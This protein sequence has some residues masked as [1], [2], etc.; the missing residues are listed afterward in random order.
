MLIMCRGNVRMIWVDAAAQHNAHVV[1]VFLSLRA[2][3]PRREPSRPV[4]P[5]VSLGS[6]SRFRPSVEDGGR[7]KQQMS[8]SG[9]SSAAASGRLSRE[10]KSRGEFHRPFQKSQGKFHDLPRDNV[11][12]VPPAF[13]PRPTT[14][15][16]EPSIIDLLVFSSLL[17]GPAPWTCA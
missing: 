5:L 3:W 13:H 9:G 2:V 4:C 15:W 1:Q 8:V 17:Q 11:K 10:P 14:H 16:S 7:E 6:C 12:V